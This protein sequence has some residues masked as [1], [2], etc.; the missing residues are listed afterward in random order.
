ML[1]TI[2]FQRIVPSCAKLNFENKNYLNILYHFF[3]LNKL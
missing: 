2:C 3:V 1:N